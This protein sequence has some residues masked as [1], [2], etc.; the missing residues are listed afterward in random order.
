[1]VGGGGGG[2]VH[3]MWQSVMLVTRCLLPSSGELHVASYRLQL[4]WPTCNQVKHMQ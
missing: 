4:P 1:M 2:G 3:V